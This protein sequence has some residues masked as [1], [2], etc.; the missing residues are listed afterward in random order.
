MSPEE[1]VEAGNKAARAMQLAFV[2]VVIALSIRACT[3]H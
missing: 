2:V 3:Q 1:R